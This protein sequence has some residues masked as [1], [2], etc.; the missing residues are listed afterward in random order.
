MFDKFVHVEVNRIENIFNNIKM[1]MDV[2]RKLVVNFPLYE[3]EIVAYVCEY[4]CDEKFF[5]HKSIENY[6][7]EKEPTF[8]RK[9]YYH[10]YNMVNL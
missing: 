7:I 5:Y 1:I 10:L 3:N 8:N 2:L 4:L 9:L 6:L